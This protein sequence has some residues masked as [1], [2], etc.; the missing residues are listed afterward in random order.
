[1]LRVANLQMCIFAQV[2]STEKKMGAQGSKDFPG[3]KF[4][5]QRRYDILSKALKPEEEKIVT[6]IWTNYK[7]N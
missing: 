1:M 2:L 4:S 3:D 5:I 7:K 6:I